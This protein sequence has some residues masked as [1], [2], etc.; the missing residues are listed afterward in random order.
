MKI[1]IR[2]VIIIKY[3][4]NIMN[5]KNRLNY[6]LMKEITYLLKKKI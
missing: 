6:Y 2:M 5:L 4:L 1:L 3:N